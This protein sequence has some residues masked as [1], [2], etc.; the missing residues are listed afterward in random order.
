MTS[1]KDYDAVHTVNRC[2]VV[3]E[4]ADAFLD[5]AKHL[6]DAA[7]DE[8]L[9]RINE[10]GTA[11]LIPEIGGD[12]D[13]WLKQNFKDMFEH[14]LWAWYTDESFWPKDRS[15]QAFKKFFN[16]RFCSV[17]IDMV[18]GQIEKDML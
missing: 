10:E 6:P 13:R 7:P 3:I 15:F 16:I 5:W 8:L 11:Y 12:P 14:E 2:A 9:N 1:Q 4:T 17:V 18:K